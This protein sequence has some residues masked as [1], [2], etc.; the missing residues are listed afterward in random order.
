MQRDVG[1]GGEEGVEKQ[2][3]H[4]PQVVLWC[5]EAERR[6][7]LESRPKQLLLQLS[8]NWSPGHFFFFFFKEKG[9]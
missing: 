8:F 2:V 3:R 7:V 9:L 4:P 1:Q 6:T 5:R